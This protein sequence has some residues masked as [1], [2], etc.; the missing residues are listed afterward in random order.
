MVVAAV[1]AAVA[2]QGG[3]VDHQGHSIAQAWVQAPALA[4]LAVPAATAPDCMVGALVA[5]LPSFEVV[6][7][8]VAGQFP[9]AGG[10]TAHSADDLLAVAVDC[11]KHCFVLVG[12]GEAL[13]H[14]EKACGMRT[15]RHWTAAVVE[16]VL[17][18][19]R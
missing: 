18:D 11:C 10:Q 19:A 6:L 4:E 3:L 5:R 1:A 2:A 14:I 8:W 9:G 16:V 17:A 13:N 7:A 15:L 12:V